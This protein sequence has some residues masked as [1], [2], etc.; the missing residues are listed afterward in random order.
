MI[1][2]NVSV[3]VS[4]SGRCDRVLRN[5]L[6]SGKEWLSRAGWDWLFSEKRIRAAGK[7]LRA[8]DTVSVGMVVEVELPGEL[9][10]LLPAKSPADFIASGP[11][12]IFVNKPSGIPTLPQFPWES[13]CFANQ[14]ST[15][16]SQKNLLS[17]EKFSALAEPPVLEG[18]FV[19]R[20]DNDTSGGIVVALTKER[21][22][23][24][25]KWIKEGKAEKTYLAA[26]HGIP[27]QGAHRFFMKEE[28][29][30]KKKR[31]LL[32][33]VEMSVPATLDITVVSQ[34]EKNALVRVK[35]S[36]GMRHVVRACLAAL[37]TPIWG[38][39]LYGTGEVALTSYPYHLLHAE[40]VKLPALE[41][42]QAEL[43]SG[44]RESLEKLDLYVEK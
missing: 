24:F 2:K 13:E 27:K 39:K 7:I 5:S 11:D 14:V 23:E 25:R 18:G 12:W 42:L 30:G 9:K 8:G 19:Q 38:D 43:P 26:T 21:K 37:K 22:M 29:S 1:S 41:I 35:T 44:F 36:G 33:S 32:E 16:V 10:G 17:P 4:E 31:A 6:I 20:L 34:K 3:P 40:T 28:I 15:L